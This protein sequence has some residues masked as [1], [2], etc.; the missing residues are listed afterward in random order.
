MA[1]ADRSQFNSHLMLKMTTISTKMCIVAPH[2]SHSAHSRS[3]AAFA[4]S[5][6]H[7]IFPLFFAGL[8]STAVASESQSESTSKGIPMKYGPEYYRVA[9]DLGNATAQYQYGLLLCNGEAIPQDINKAVSYFRNASAQGHFKAQFQFGLCYFN[10]RGV[11]QNFTQAAVYFKLSAD[12]GYRDAQFWYSRCLSEGLGIPPNADLALD[13]LKLSA[14][15]QF[16]D[17]QFSL[18][19]ANLNGTSIPVNL[20]NAIHYLREAASQGHLDA[21]IEFAKLVANNP[22]NDSDTNTEAISYLR[23]HAD[24]G[25]LDAIILYAKVLREGI[26]TERNLTASAS[27]MNQAADSGDIESQ[28][29]YG[30]YLFDEHDQDRGIYYLKLSADGGYARAQLKYGMCLLS[31]CGV[32]M[33]NCLGL[34]YLNHGADGG[35]VEAQFTYASVLEFINPVLSVQ[36]HRLAASQAL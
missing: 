11:P 8:I 3:N 19:L 27:Y 18:G 4:C 10:G 15:Q 29:Q 25:R 31:G 13:Y 6:H 1:S 22:T 24:N 36:Y 30:M 35:D 7:L 28:Y 21:Q 2:I 23:D 34:S 16:A 17:A 12:Q 33:N 9:A 32:A 14:S 5:L 26:I 20:D